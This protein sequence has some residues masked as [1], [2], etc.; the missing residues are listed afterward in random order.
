MAGQGDCSPNHWHSYW[1]GPHANPAAR[2]L[3]LRYL[4]PI[5]VGNELPSTTVVRPASS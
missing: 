2:Q 3:V 4:P 5:Q 1:V